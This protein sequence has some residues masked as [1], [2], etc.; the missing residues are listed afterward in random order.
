MSD[1][2]WAPALCWSCGIL[3]LVCCAIVLWP[4]KKRGLSRPVQDDRN[5]ISAWNRIR[6]L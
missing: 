6:G 4:R 5:S 3:I 2:G 1:L